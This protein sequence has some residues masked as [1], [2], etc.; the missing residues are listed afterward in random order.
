MIDKETLDALNEDIENW[1]SIAKGN[2]I[3][4]SLKCLCW[5]TIVDRS[6][7]C[8]GCLI[9]KYTGVGNCRN[10]PNFRWYGP[11]IEEARNHLALLKWIKYQELNG[12][13]E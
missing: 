10:T 4:T 2:G 13:T 1:E 11:N 12:T 6:G 9:K 8:N 7:D 3:T 5:A